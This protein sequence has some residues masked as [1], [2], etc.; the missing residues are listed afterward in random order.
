MSGEAEATTIHRARRVLALR[1]F[2][3]LWLVTGV[4]S[5][6]DWLTVLSLAGLASAIAPGSTGLNFA[7]SGVLFANLLPG[8]LFAPIGGLLADRFDRRKVMAA[9]DLV[10]CALLV[11]IVLMDTYWWIF[12]GTFL[13]QVATI[14]WIPCKDAAL[15]NLLR[16]PDQIESAAQ[17]GLVMTYGFSVAVG[18]GLFVAVSGAG[19]ALHLPHDLFGA[20]GLL[21]LAVLIA[22]ALYLTSAV[23]IATR[24][25]ELS[26]RGAP[27]SGAASGS[28]EE[29]Q[30]VLAMLRD[31]VRYIR[32]TPLVRGLLIGMMGAFAAGGAVV[33]A[34]QPYAL[35]LL[36]GQ[37]TF[38]LLLIALFAGLVTGMIGAPKLARR[39]P[40]ERLFGVAIVV[41]GIALLG[42]AL[43]PMLAFSL[44]VVAIVGACAG[45]AF[46]TGITIIGS[47]VDDGMRGRINAVY[48]SMLKVVV[49]C[50]IAVTPLLVTLVS[51]WK[52]T[53]W[54]DPIQIDG[55]RP[56]ILGA[57]VLAIAVG[58]V[59]H[60]QMGAATRREP[61]LRAIRDA[62][63]W[64]A[65]RVTG[66][67]IT[68]EGTTA[69]STGAQARRLADWLGTGERDVLLASDPVLDD[70]RLTALTS[71]ASLSG[72]RARALAAAAVRADIVD[73]SVQ[74]ALDAGSIVV[75]E[76]FA[77][78]PIAHLCVATGL[79]ADEVDGLAF[80]AAG[81]LRPDL[82]VLLD[83][84]PESASSGDAQWQVREVLR[85][86]ATTSPAR[87][88]VVSGDGGEDEVAERVRF[89][90]WAALTGRFSVPTPA[91]DPALPA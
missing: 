89:A 55:T 58:A 60:R 13:T 17:L 76:R 21:K 35:S 44:V 59:A 45:A 57:G 14:M 72:P 66:M 19:T 39:L 51:S 87:Y 31:S 11:S 63:S 3:R 33:G 67:L 69:A 2:R 32:G 83:T 91:Y 78:S 86:M 8:L 26:L 40:H 48:Q 90:V 25:P 7:F 75:M 82:V 5:S 38:G 47:R 85:E 43:S 42:V 36:G 73:R 16:R 27:S 23:T 28:D 79:D 24:L 54:G 62:M 61:I 53:V 37:A 30:G 10:R 41:A 65:K 50:S 68:V 70:D 22:A 88:L 34:A 6:A 56:V 1:P 4:C 77:D 64:R 49:G 52:M 74:P 29:K 15:P 46:L 71:L 84:A 9:A 81:T 12:V 80:W 18:G 20:N